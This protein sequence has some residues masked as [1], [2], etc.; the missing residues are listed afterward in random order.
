M[1]RWSLLIAL[2][3]LTLPAAALADVPPPDDYVES[4]A[5]TYYVK[6]GVLCQECSA[7]HG[8]PDACEPLTG[9]GFAQQC[10]TW[11]A[12]SWNEVWCKQ[13]PAWTGEPVTIGVDAELLR[14]DEKKAKRKAL[15]TCQLGGG[16]GAGILALAMLAMAALRRRADG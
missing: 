16:D 1:I 11:G 10:R 8:E 2:L 12:S 9:R 7:W 3:A 13:D 14:K 6:P 4:C 15:F 5:S